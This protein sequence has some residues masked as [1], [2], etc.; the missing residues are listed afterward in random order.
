M[1][2]YEIVTQK[3]IKQLERGEVPWRKPWNGNPY[4]VNWMTQKPYQGINRL[5]LPPGEYA[6]FK[7]IKDAGGKVKKGAKASIVV[8]WKMNT[9][10]KTIADDATGEELIHIDVVPVLRYYSVFEINTQCEGLTSKQ[11][12]GKFRHSPIQEAEKII[13][14]MSNKPI[15][16]RH[17]GKAYYRPSNDTISI[18]DKSDFESIE[19]YYSTLFHELVHSTG[20][21][22]RLGRFSNKDIAAFGTETYSKEELVAEIGSSF[23]Q[24][25]TGLKVP[26]ANSV[27]Y[28][29]GWLK[30]LRNDKRLIVEAASKAQ[31]AVDYI[32]GEKTHE[33]SDG[34]SGM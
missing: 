31:K 1:S 2:V 8:F 26:F 12:I 13:E 34:G 16:T 18:P 25:E 9:I 20:H 3:I 5:L 7:Q 27:A 30:A 19:A 32:L 17:P 24:A 28:I 22:K 23:L 15:I 6:T 29:Q 33:T 10:T 21:E 14:N 4:P 11:G